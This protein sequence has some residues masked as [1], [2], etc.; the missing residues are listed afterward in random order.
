MK[1]L[2]EVEM[3]RKLYWVAY[4]IDKFVV[5]RSGLMDAY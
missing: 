5:L 3:C 1:D 2:L 4:D